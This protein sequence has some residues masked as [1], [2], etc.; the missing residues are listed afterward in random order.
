[1]PCR[2]VVS[3][4]SPSGGMWQLCVVL[5]NNLNVAFYHAVRLRVQGR[6]A[7]LADSQSLHN[8]MQEMG[9]EVTALVTMQFSTYT[10]AA[11]EIGR[12]LLIGNG[13]Y[14][15]P[16]SKIIHCNKEVSASLV[17]PWEGSSYVDGYSL[18]RSS[19][20]ILVHLVPIPGPRAATGRTG[21][22]L[23]APFP[24]IKSCL[25][26]KESLSNLIQGFINTQMTSWRSIM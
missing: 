21:I 22:A 23:P 12:C 19:H 7:R 15:R 2:D 1:M 13:I 4:P 24:N 20:V 14:F 10:E 5:L 17:T 3:R 8:F 16:L 9:L 6:G 11:E 18:E 25:E 26:P